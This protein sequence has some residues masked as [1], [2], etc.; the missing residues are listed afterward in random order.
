MSSGTFNH[1]DCKALAF[2]HLQLGFRDS[3]GSLEVRTQPEC[4]ANSSRIQP[5][6]T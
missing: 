3:G 1:D 5:I 2:V 6:H 4:D